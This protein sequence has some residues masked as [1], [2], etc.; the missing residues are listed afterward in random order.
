MTQP[1]V[2]IEVTNNV[3]WISLNR[4]KV[5]NSL[6][7]EMVDL[8][9]KQ[10][11]KWRDDQRISFVCIT[12]EGTKGLCA[13]GDMRVFY[14]LKES[15]V[16]EA[17]FDFFS[18]EYQMDICIHHYPKPVLVYMDGIVMGGGV[19]ISIG[20]SHRIVTENTKWA[21]PEMNIG[22]YPDVG[23]SY[24]LNKMPGAIGRYLALT[25][26]IV[27]AFDI[28]YAGAADFYLDSSNWTEL[29]SEILIKKWSTTSVD[30]ELSKLIKKYSTH[31]QVDS[32]QLAIL[33][34][35]INKHFVYD[36]IEEILYSLENADS[37]NDGVHW[38]NE[39]KRTLLSKS[40]I[41]LKVTLHQLQ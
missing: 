26:K 33:Q 5:L 8:I 18:I 22:F 29:K 9:H 21:M 31:V 40:P 17:A 32:S 2:L 13:G 30:S 3:G 28:I 36:S 35:K 10:L 6:N 11:Q 14:D 25:S 16:N 7:V 23:A 15:N 27:N 1:S 19:G 34:E 37:E 38:T 20:A 39:T 4:P 12:G 41:S 24:F